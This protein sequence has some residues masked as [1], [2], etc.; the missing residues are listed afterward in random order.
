MNLS[1]LIEKN[2][3]ELL[4]LNL[5]EVTE[6]RL[7]APVKELSDIFLKGKCLDL[8]TVSYSEQA[9]FN[10]EPQ[11]LAHQRDA[12]LAE[13]RDSNKFKEL[14]WSEVQRAFKT[15]I[16][17]ES[18]PFFGM[19]AKTYH[20][21]LKHYYEKPE[22]IE[23][24]RQYLALMETINKPEPSESEKKQKN[25]EACE[26]AFETYKNT[27]V[28]PN[29]HFK[30]YQT[31]MDLG[32]IK[33]TPEEKKAISGPIKL[34]YQKELESKKKNGHINASQL[35]ELMISLDSNA[36]LISRVRKEALKRYFDKL[37]NENLNLK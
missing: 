21:F 11:I 34:E 35:A 37:K 36:T 9:Q 12:L 22:R 14:T 5:K 19:C 33:W 4:P 26:W 25:F 20:Q 32:L 13:L 16:R 7:E 3:F 29:G 2:A 31:L 30:F 10:I 27:G 17:G 1:T 8:I 15:G 24:M 28:I 18:G 6:A 23:G